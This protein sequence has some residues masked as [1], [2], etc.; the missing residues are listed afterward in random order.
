MTYKWRKNECDVDGIPFVKKASV[1][2]EKDGVQETFVTQEE[3]DQAWADGWHDTGRPETADSAIDEPPKEEKEEKRGR[4]R[5]KKGA[6]S[7]II[8]DD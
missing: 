6:L 2:L 4:G 5:P 8:G 3:V 1:V 7:L